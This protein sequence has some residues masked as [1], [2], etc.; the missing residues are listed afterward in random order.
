MELYFGLQST[1]GYN[2]KIQTLYKALWRGQNP[3]NVTRTGKPN[4]HGKVFRCRRAAA[5][6]K[7]SSLFIARDYSKA[8]STCSC[9]QGEDLDKNRV[10]QYYSETQNG[11]TTRS[12]YEWHNRSPNS[13]V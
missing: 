7:M 2:N 5:P 3:F 6:R 12:F 11:G 10:K 9:N 1:T 13:N 4:I 8:K